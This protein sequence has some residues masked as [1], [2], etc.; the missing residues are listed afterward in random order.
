MC[1]FFVL[2]F[3]Y[4]ANNFTLHLF[5]HPL[6]IYN[7]FSKFLMKMWKE[8]LFT[9]LKC[10]ACYTQGFMQWSFDFK[11]S[12]YDVKN[13]MKLSLNLQICVWWYPKRLVNKNIWL[14]LNGYSYWWPMSWNCNNLSFYIVQFFMFRVRMGK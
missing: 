11:S 14:L 13:N 5:G 2:V 10:K 3:P 4:V 7:F 8:N 9:K 12:L 6:Y 1:C